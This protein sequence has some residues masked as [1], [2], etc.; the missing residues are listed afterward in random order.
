MKILAIGDVV[1]KRSIAYLSDRL[2]KL[3]DRLRPDFVV[4]NGENASEI[5]GL[6]AADAEALLD[7]GIDLLTL[8]NHAF[9]Y[10]DIGPFLDSHTDAII[11]PANYPAACPGQGYA[12]CS[13]GGLRILCMNVSGQLYLDTLH[14]PFDTIDA[15]LKREAGNY[16]LSLLDIHA[17]ATSE[18]L[19]IGHYFDGRISVMF[20]TH[21]H[22]PTADEQIL[23]KG[24]GYITDLGMTGPADGI[25]G[26]NVQDVL[27]KFRTHMPTRFTVATGEIK[28][29]AV[30]F[31]LSNTA[32]F[33]VTG[34]ERVVF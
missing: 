32:P 20:G 7:C 16:D 4:A 14:D 2:W 23:P 34:V 15:I 19:A 11:R 12:I 29:N 17:E 18:K 25:L 31:T 33:R 5:H 6:T 30:L 28:A 1:G 27:Q 8:G 21:T 22:V 10:R 13:V 24:S 3:R 26:V 9:G